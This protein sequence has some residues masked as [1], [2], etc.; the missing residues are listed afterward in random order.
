MSKLTSSVHLSPD[1]LDKTYH[2]SVG[3]YQH[4]WFRSF[5]VKTLVNDYGYLSKLTLTLIRF[6]I[7]YF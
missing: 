3:L 2:I 5:Q 7:I 6:K 4:I 1:L